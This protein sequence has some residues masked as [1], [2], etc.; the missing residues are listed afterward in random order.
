MASLYKRHRSSYWWIKYRDHSGRIVRKSTLL[1]VGRTD[2][3]RQARALQSKYTLAE[4]TTPKDD[5]RW[6]H[7]VDSFITARYLGAAINGLNTTGV[8]P[9]VPHTLRRVRAQWR[10]FYYF[11]TEAGVHHPAALQRPHI[12][13]Y[14]S[15]R[16][17]TVGVNTI[18]SELKTLSLIMREAVTR[19]YCQS[20]P[21]SNLGFKSAPPK[22]RGELTD[23]HVEIVRREIAERIAREGLTRSTRF[24]RVS[25]E[26][27]LHQGCRMHETCFPLSAV[28]FDHGELHLIGKGGRPF[29]QPIHPDLMP[30][31][32]ELRDQGCART[33]EPPPRA[34]LLWYFLF[35]KLRA[36]HPDMADISFHST[37]VR[38]I[39]RL[40]RAG[41]PEAVVMKFVNHSSTTVHRIY[42][43][44]S[45]AEMTP[46]WA[47]LSES[48]QNPGST[49]ARAAPHPPSFGA[50]A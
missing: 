4:Q 22:Q 5:S 9:A 24:L 14:T 39:S 2:H 46:V 19:G 26:I 20:N 44:V 1:E 48:S 16:Q 13:N 7:W 34:S 30:L 11:L 45:H 12:F 10:V 17:K 21:V 40:A 8:N 15:E 47:A 27:A 6:E 18:L 28:D 43:R 31:L 35:R 29:Q 37:R 49:P 25:F 32:K 3:L 42:R 23:A 36:K 41:L 33:F 38:A 50:H